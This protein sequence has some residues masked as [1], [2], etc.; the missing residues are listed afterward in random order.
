MTNRQAAEAG[1]RGS[2]TSW[3]YLRMPSLL[4]AT[5]PPGEDLLIPGGVTARDP[6]ARTERVSA[7]F[8]PKGR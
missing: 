1:Y 3:R 6:A 4:G 5:R 7:V 8:C 2:L